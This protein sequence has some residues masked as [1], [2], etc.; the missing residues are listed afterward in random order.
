MYPL[1][2]IKFEF[3]DARAFLFRGTKWSIR[4]ATH[5]LSL[6]HSMYN[7][8]MFLFNFVLQPNVLNFNKYLNAVN[9]FMLTHSVGGGSVS[10]VWLLA[11]RA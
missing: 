4:R 9:S 6:E 3:R 1:W 2:P 10:L 11:E 8:G 7:I 5:L